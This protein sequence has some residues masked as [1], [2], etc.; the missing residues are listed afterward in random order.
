[1]MRLPSL[2]WKE[3]VPPPY[4]PSGEDEGVG[5]PGPV[6]Q[7]GEDSGSDEIGRLPELRQVPRGVLLRH[8]APGGRGQPLPL[9]EVAT[10]KH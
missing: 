1:M 8:T 3:G 7:L 6:P 2:I 4:G 9:R 5:P 10:A